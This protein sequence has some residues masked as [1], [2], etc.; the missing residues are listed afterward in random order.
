MAS[1]DKPNDRRSFL[2]LAGAAPVA[3]LAALGA[4]ASGASSV[5]AGRLPERAAFLACVGETFECATGALDSHQIRLAR[6]EP[7]PHPVS[8]VDDGRS[9]RLFFEVPEGRAIAQ[10]THRFRHDRLGEFALFVS[11]SDA[12]GRVL[13]AVFNR[14]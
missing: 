7:L 12:R 3:G 5:N 2:R 4:S 9:F 8:G 1:M 13:E 6:V 14:L 11:P 10:D